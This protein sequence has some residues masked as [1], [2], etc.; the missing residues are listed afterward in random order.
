MSELNAHLLASRVLRTVSS[1][2]KALTWWA[3]E[4][5]A[6]VPPTLH[7]W[8]DSDDRHPILR[9]DLN[10]ERTHEP[11][12]PAITVDGFDI[13]NLSPALQA[14]VERFGCI[15]MLSKS[16]VLRQT[17]DLPLAAADEVVA[18]SSFLIERITPFTV[19]QVRYSS[20]VIEKDRIRQVVRVEITVVPYVS[21]DACLEQLEAWKVPISGFRVEGDKR[22]LSLSPSAHKLQRPTRQN[23]CYIR[24]WKLLLATS[25]I[26]LAVGTPLIA[27]QVHDEAAVLNAEVSA[28]E[29]AGQNG[30]ALRAEVEALTAV[31]DFIP[32]QISGPYAI[33][34]LAELA[35]L[36]P[37][38]TW[39]FNVD[40]TSSEVRI[41]G[42]SAAIPTVLER[43]RNGRTFG[44][45]ELLGSVVHGSE[46]ERFEIGLHIM[47]PPS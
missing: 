28:A 22:D 2:Y 13:A 33:E 40:M 24:P 8:L 26:V 37:D 31:S 19:D 39:L 35:E 46:R 4:L 6:L 27:A 36:L 23:S 42:L 14:R 32:D 29:K 25:V 44:A 1:A 21:V 43:L 3:R 10:D 17:L 45:P 30:S 38:D 7:D 47:R 18:A 41:A 34:V 5:V 11:F 9:I 16:R 20:V 12:D 15:L